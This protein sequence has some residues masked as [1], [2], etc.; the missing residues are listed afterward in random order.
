MT[1]PEIIDIVL[2]TFQVALVAILAITV[3]GIALGFALA[4]HSF[5]GKSLIETL[6]ALP[7]VL[8]PVAVGLLLLLTFSQTTPVGAFIQ[9]TLGWQIV[10]TWKAAAIAAAVVSFPLLVRSSQQAF[11]GVPLRLEHVARSLGSHGPRLFFTITLPLARQGVIYGLLL[12]FCRALGEFGATTMVAG[13]IPG[14]TETLALGTYSSVMN[15]RDREAFVLMGISMVIAFAAMY[16]A[17][18]YVKK[19]VRQ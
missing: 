13:N 18:R 14:K 16:L 9:N 6:V 17:E 10:Y 15:N 19:T 5:R 3:P 11:H 1:Y 12:A 2:R 8:P 4:R 7:M